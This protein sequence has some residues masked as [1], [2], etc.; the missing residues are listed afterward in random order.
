MSAR[1]ANWLAFLL[2]LLLQY[3]RKVLGGSGLRPEIN[4][5][6]PR[7]ISLDDTLIETYLLTSG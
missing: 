7:R 1:K 2:T 5:Q 3:L 4:I 6:I